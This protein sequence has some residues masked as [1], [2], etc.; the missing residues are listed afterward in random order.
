VKLLERAH[1]V[2]L[3]SPD[4]VSN[5]TNR[6]VAYEATTNF[7]RYKD[8]TVK[9]LGQNRAPAVVLENGHVACFI[10]AVR[11]KAQKEGNNNCVSS[12]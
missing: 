12:A 8:G 9:S 6:G 2:S 11:P 10:F 5:L 1:R 7:M 3:T 4:G